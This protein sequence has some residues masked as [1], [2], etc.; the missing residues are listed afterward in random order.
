MGIITAYSNKQ[1]VTEA[2]NDIK[3]TF[4]NVDPKLIVYFASSSF[5]GEL[6]SKEMKNSFS[7]TDMFGCSTAG[8][9]VS[10]K[11]LKNSIVAMSLD[12]EVISDV[13]IEVLENISED[14]EKSVE[15]AFN[16]FE[17]KL[18][19]KMSDLSPK[20]YV[21]I[22]LI[23]GL[24]VVE[25]KVMDKIGVRTNIMFIGGSAGDDCK[26]EKTFVYANGK[27]YPNSAVLVL[28]KPSNGFDYIK[29]QSFCPMK[30]II[31]K[32]TKVNEASREILEFNE[33]PAAEVY[34]EVLGTT[35]DKV[36]DK[37]MHNPVGLLVGDD[38]FVRSPQQI[39]ENSMVFYCAVGEGMELALLE[40]TDI[41]KDTKEAVDNKKNELGNISGIINFNC[42]LR[43]LEL[44]Q[45][46]LTGAYGELFTDIPTIGFSTYGEEFIGHINQTATMLIFK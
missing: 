8:E 17:N 10:G 1:S 27:S 14:A 35:V 12:K 11:M 41:I 28:L 2:V 13:K 15:D 42:I 46:D 20:E 21:G 45:K 40:A 43:T 18:G 38:I 23:D 25:E 44:E 33:K 32:A 4:S 36:S 24:S 16:S 9:I 39:K 34:S 26:F 5:E 31:L 29:T 6:L 19:S 3:N 22:I 37:F 30:D 7:D